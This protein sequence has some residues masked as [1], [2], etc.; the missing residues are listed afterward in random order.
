[1]RV[2]GGSDSSPAERPAYQLLVDLFFRFFL[3]VLTKL[4]QIF[5]IDL[6]VSLGA[7]LGRAWVLVKGPRT[8]RVRDQLEAAMP[9]ELPGRLDIW[10]K[11][12]FVH[13]GRGLAEL[14]LLRGRRRGELLERIEVEGLENV[15]AA[16]RSSPSG[17][18]LIVTAHCGNWELACAKI[19]A[20]G[21]PVSVVYR[22]LRQRELNRAFL[23]LRANQNNVAGADGIDSSPKPPLEQIPM[24][25]AGIRL[26]RAFEAGRKVLVLLDQNARREEGMFVSF[27]GRPASTRYGPLA[28][29][30]LRGIPVLMAFVRRSPDGRTHR[31]RIQPALQLESGVS[32]DEEVLR[33]NVQKVTAAIEQEIRASPG[34]WIW[35][36]RR[37]RTQPD[38]AEKSLSQAKE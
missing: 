14:V 8:G 3:G 33:R 1:M 12:V 32:D 9:E 27:F 30:G 37:W 16:E 10:S 4:F 35:T 29:A 25:R 18:L 15:E 13:L 21:I 38:A 24:G 20:M 5:P 11:E 17:G 28:L 36:H 31:L 19:V 7:G 34:Q 2:S 26:V 6:S 22:S 23:D